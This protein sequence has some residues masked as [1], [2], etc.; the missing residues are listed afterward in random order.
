M[1][2]T[3]CKLEDEH[4]THTFFQVCL[5]RVSDEEQTRK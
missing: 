2:V 1:I 5:V 3:D 4:K